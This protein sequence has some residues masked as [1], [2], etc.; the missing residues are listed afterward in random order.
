MTFPALTVYLNTDKDVADCCRATGIDLMRVPEYVGQGKLEKTKD[1]RIQ[2]YFAR[3]QQP[4]N[5]IRKVNP[6]FNQPERE[7]TVA[8]G[9]VYKIPH[10]KFLRWADL[11]QAPAEQQQASPPPPQQQQQPAPNGHQPLPQGPSKHAIAASA[12]LAGQYISFFD[13]CNTREEAE[14]VR[15]NLREVSSRLI[16]SDGE[17]VNQAIV[18]LRQRLA[19]PAQQPAPE[20]LPQYDDNYQPDGTPF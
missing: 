19:P 9:Q 10:Y 2:A 16:G 12:M 15:N 18:R 20:Q 14:H 13:A 17:L 1:P 3:F 7:A 8:R 6:K 5:V 4:V 11:P